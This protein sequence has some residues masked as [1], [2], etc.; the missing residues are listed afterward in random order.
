M[1]KRKKHK[2]HIGSIGFHTQL[3]WNEFIHA[4][5]KAREAC[6]IILDKKDVSSC[7]IGILYL[8]DKL[9]RILEKRG[10]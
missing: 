3:T 9:A 10:V 5:N 8:S 2:K 6:E 1:G 7:K 4:S